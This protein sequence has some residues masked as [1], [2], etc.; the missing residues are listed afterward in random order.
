MFCS[1][2]NIADSKNLAKGSGLDKVLKD[3][4]YEIA[5]N[6][7]YDGYQWGLASVV[8]NFFDKKIALG[9]SVISKLTTNTNEV[10]P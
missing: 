1:R 2:C 6:P 7:W 3:R 4:A 8:Y 5:L 10:L 9:A